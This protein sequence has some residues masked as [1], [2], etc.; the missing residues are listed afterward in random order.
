MPVPVPGS[1]KSTLCHTTIRNEVILEGKQLPDL[2]Q[3][4]ANNVH[5]N[6]GQCE[7]WHFIDS[8]GM[9]KQLKY[10]PQ[11]TFISG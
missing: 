5:E 11:R 4:D 1:G 9:P 2:A 10:L 7:V 3:R 6:L 8:C